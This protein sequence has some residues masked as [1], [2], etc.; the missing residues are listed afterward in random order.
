M[1]KRSILVVVAAS[2]ILVPL[3]AWY[4][5]GGGNDRA[6]N[7]SNETVVV[8]R[9]TFASAVSALGTVKPRIGA[10]VRVGSRLSGRVRRLR[11]NVG[12]RV[13]KNQVIAELETADLDALIAERR[14]EHRLAESRRRAVDVLAPAEE[15]KA[16]AD[17]DRYAATVKLAT[18]ESE[19]AQTLLRQ[20]MTTPAEANAAAERLAVA[21]AQL[22]AARR[23][24][25]LVRI[26]TIERRAQTSAEV[27]RA[28]AMVEA[29]LVD[30]SFAT[31]TAPIAGIVASVA[32]Q[33]GET[34]AAGLSAPT[35]LTIVD[36]D[37]LQVNAYVDEV[38]IGKIKTDQRATF[39]VDAF[40]ARDFT[41][42]IGAIYPSATI[43]DN[44]VK[45]IAAIDID[46]GHGGV[47]RPEMTA[48]V[49][50]TLDDRAALAIPARAIRRE[51]GAS[52]VYALVAGRPQPRTIR[53]GWRDGA[54]AEVVQGLSEGDRILLDPPV[55]SSEK[56]P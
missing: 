28:S 8:S 4:G 6:G 29:A 46:A 49:R 31:I 13:T 2:T 9:R 3:V 35:F 10:E 25:Q 18:E 50:I 32:T 26:E 22:E 55:A 11:A 56:A 42:V 36:L 15:A 53:V 47:L 12:D 17:V 39:T 27:D 54:W 5:A 33:E 38:D 7:G 44:V 30:R 37:R 34:V 24:L 48:S 19:R 20:R 16:Q 52:V 41:G 45:Y 21:Q 51:N 14:A 1:T 23:G 43:Q 40:P